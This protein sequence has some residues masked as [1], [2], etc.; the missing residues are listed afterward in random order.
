MLPYARIPAVA[1]IPNMPVNIRSFAKR[2]AEVCK[3][4]Y[5]EGPI[6]GKLAKNDTGLDIDDI[7]GAYMNSPDN[8]FW[9]AESPEGQVVGMI[10][11][12]QHQSG[13][14]EI[15]RLRVR[16]DLRGRGVGSQLLEVAIKFCKEKQHLKVIL[17]TAMDP[18][19]ALKLFDKAHFRLSRTRVLGDKTLCYFYL[20]LY[21]ADTVRKPK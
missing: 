3:R 2:D 4:L 13:E 10:G 9:V 7:A 19:P 17:D 1:E 5:K 6:S 16:H 12:Q 20:D 14:G 8:H 15:R 18:Q 11:V 21:T